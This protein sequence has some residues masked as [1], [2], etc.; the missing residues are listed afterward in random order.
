MFSP[1]ERL[2][3]CPT[4]VGI[5]WETHEQTTWCATK[6]EVDEDDQ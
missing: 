6:G 2:K 5:E 3:G 4:Q 1:D